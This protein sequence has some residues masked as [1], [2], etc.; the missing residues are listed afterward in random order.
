MISKVIA[1]GNRQQAPC[2]VNNDDYDESTDSVSQIAGE[3]DHVGT[4]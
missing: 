2:D 1:K 4:G 3:R